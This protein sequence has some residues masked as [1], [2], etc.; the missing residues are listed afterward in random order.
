MQASEKIAGGFFVAGG[1]TPELLDKLEEAFDEVAFGVE[2]EVAIPF[3][4]AV[5]FWRDDR[6]DGSDFKA[7][8]KAASVVAF[9][10]EEGLGPHLGGERFGLVDVVDLPAGETERQRVAQ[11]VDDHMDFGGQAAARAAYGLVE[12]PFLRAPALC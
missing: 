5:R 4:L 11:G 7:R 10:G 12:A 2:R 9:V 1:D 6:L 8:N 3:D